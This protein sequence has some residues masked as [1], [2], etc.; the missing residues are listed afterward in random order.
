MGTTYDYVYEYD[1][2]DSN[3]N[4]RSQKNPTQ[5]FQQSTY[6]PP[7]AST[8][9][10]ANNMD[11]L[12]NLQH[13]R[14]WTKLYDPQ[15]ADKVNNETEAQVCYTKIS[16]FFFS[17]LLTCQFPSSLC[18]LPSENISHV[19]CRDNEEKQIYT[20]TDFMSLCER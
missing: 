20:H 5:S 11:P 12:V 14:I 10:R 2:T 7:A 1:V 8:F 15:G 13:D 3:R 6:H 17:T 18:R 16:F 9:G 19:I 4:N